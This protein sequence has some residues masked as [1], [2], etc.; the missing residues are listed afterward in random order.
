MDNFKFNTTT[1]ISFGWGV[2]S[3]VA[4]EFKITAPSKVLVVT[5]RGIVKSGLLDKLLSPL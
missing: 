3:E 1:L 2:V 4:T 5:D